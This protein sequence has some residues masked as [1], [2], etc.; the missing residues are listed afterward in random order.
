MVQEY[1]SPCIRR[2]YFMTLENI[3]DKHILLWP[4]ILERLDKYNP[5]RSLNINQ[6]SIWADKTFKQAFVLK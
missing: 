4:T 3:Y 5:S 2:M 1:N 6:Q